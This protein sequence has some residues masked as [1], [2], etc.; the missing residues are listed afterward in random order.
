MTN[1]GRLAIHGGTPVRGEPFPPRAPFDEQCVDLA[2]QAIRSGSLYG[3]GGRFTTEFA[4]EFAEFYDAAHGVTTSSGTAAVHTALA[5]FVPEPGSEVITAP[6]TDAGSVIPILA[7]GCVPIFADID[8]HYGMDP[9]A[10][11]KA[12]TDRTAAIIVVHL[13]GGASDM[14]A[15]AEITARRGIPVI[16]DCSQAHAT[17][18]DGRWLGRFG[19]VGA[20][21]LQQSKHLTTGD[22]GVVITDD[23]VLAERM[24]TFRDKGWSRGRVGPRSYP[25]LGM[26]YRMTEL[27]AAVGLP[28]LARLPAV[29]ARR[30]QL[31][32][33]I[34]ARL[35]D[36]PGVRPF[37]PRNRADA[38][39]W[40]YPF[41]VV[42]HDVA[43]FAEALAA[44]GVGVQPGYIGEPIYR[45]MSPVY[46]NFSF[47][48]SAFPFMEPFHEPVDY[49]PGTCPNAE[50][51]LQ[52][53]VIF[54]LHEDLSDA[55]ADDVGEAIGKVARGFAH[56][57]A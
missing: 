41:E 16:E 29:V 1:E 50:A 24:S 12:I 28:Q 36:A 13:F 11:E 9:A 45:C 8:P 14:P 43:Q 25:I 18:L 49:G 32:G 26:N 34:D 37:V 23:P 53:L 15:I 10:V 46:D 56:T 47:A 22:G 21:S 4:A 31:A 57:A 30:R 52:R 38:S 27:Q 19:Q 35:A 51:A 55:D 48:T 54:W 17:R 5:A 6:I 39:Y 2:A 33:R 44:E 7:L 3:S 20:F 40:T 42:G